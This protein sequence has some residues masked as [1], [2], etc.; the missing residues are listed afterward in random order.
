MMIKRDDEQTPWTALNDME[1]ATYAVSCSYKS[2]KQANMTIVEPMTIKVTNMNLR[3]EKYG[4]ILP[5]QHEE[6][7]LV[8][9]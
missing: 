2:C 6:I 1:N 5:M 3:F 8:T 4:R 9:E 7:K